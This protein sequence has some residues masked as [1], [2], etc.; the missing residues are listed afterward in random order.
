MKGGFR[1][2]G[3]LFLVAFGVLFAFDGMTDTVQT[4]GGLGIGLI[5]LSYLF[6]F[7]SGMGIFLGLTILLLVFSFVLITFSDQFEFPELVFEEDEEEIEEQDWEDFW[8]EDWEEEEEFSFEE[9]FESGVVEDEKFY[10]HEHSWQDNGR[11]KYSSTFEVKK[12]FF[13]KSRSS[14]EKHEVY[15]QSD[16]DYWENVYDFLYKTDK[17]KVDE[18]LDM[19]NDIGKK[20]KLNSGEFADMVVTSIQDIPYVLVHELTHKEA[21]REW[22]GYITEYHETGGPCLDQIRYGIQSPVEFM[23]NF[24]G[25]CDTR[26]VFCYLVLTHFGYDV[27]VLASDI[28]GHAILGIAGNYRGKYVEYGGTKYYGWE[29]T[30]TGYEPGMMSPDCKNMKFWY[31]SLPSKN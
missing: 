5:V 13:S 18:I 4:G 12:T 19:Y 1:I 3:F 9:E 20:N 31:V 8:E 6:K 15:E 27:T 11:N 2:L 10:L 30:A 21:E 24:K 26:A 29:T 7:R 14:R 23:S 22:G 16:H 25:D 28:Y 17:D